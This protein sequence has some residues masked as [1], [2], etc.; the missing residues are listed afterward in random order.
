MSECCA[1]TPS[2][3]LL[4]A[5][6]SHHVEVVSTVRNAILPGFLIIL[7]AVLVTKTDGSGDSVADTVVASTGRGAYCTV[8][9]D[10]PHRD[11]AGTQ[12]VATG[13]FRCDKPGSQGLTMTVQLQREQADG[14]WATVASGQFQASGA[15]TTG[16]AGNA[17][18]SRTVSAACAEGVYR[19]RVEGVS[20]RDGGPSALRGRST[21]GTRNPCT[22]RR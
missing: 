11:S 10:S 8:I 9:A 19:T 20:L 15:A 14:S 13:R 1:A 21:W 18:R 6:A 17:Q 16:D 3:G 7:F 12:I 22:L 4:K 5:I 2:G